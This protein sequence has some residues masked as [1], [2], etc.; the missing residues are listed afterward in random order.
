MNK[1]F[2]KKAFAAVALMFMAGTASADN[3]LSIKGFCAGAGETVDGIEICLDNDDQLS[4]L[5]FELEL[6]AGVTLVTTTGNTIFTSTGRIDWYI[7]TISSSTS[8]TGNILRKDATHY[9]FLIPNA[10]QL[11]I[12]GNSGAI[13][14]F[15]L[16]ASADFN[17]I[18]N[19]KLTNFKATDRAGDAVTTYPGKGEVAEFANEFFSSNVD[20]IIENLVENENCAL[21]EKDN[22]AVQDVIK[23]TQKAVAAGEMTQAEAN[24]AIREVVI[25]EEKNA[26]DINL[27]GEFNIDDVQDILDAF[28]E[29]G[30]SDNLWDVNG[31]G[32]INIDD[33]QELLD[34]YME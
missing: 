34:K 12:V 5:Q 9:L 15:A 22:A 33:V 1:N 30:S 10:N 11:P 7:P 32:D 6:P 20:A 27:D 31:D 24:A 18:S 14:K 13:I 26:G 16:K 29:T 23:D 28:M 3:V 8:G 21:V 19:I 2:F 4:S 25:A 17:V